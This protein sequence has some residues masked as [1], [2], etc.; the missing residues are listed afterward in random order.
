MAKKKRPPV[1]Q[2]TWSI[3][4]VLDPGTPVSSVGCAGGAIVVGS[5][6]LLRVAPGGWMLQQRPV[7]DGLELPVSLA[8]EP[9]PPFRVAIGPEDG[10]VVIFTDTSTASSIM[11][12]G[13]S[14]TRGSK[15]AKELC[16]VVNDGESSLY[17]RTDDDN[18]YRMQADAIWDQLE[19][20]PVRAVA[21]DDAG[22]FAA[23]TVVDGRPRVYITPDGGDRFQ[24]R[25][26]GVDVEAAPDAPAFMALAGTAVV[27]G[28]GDSGPM[29]SRDAGADTLRYPKL[30]RAFSAAFPGPDPQGSIYV[31]QQRRG[32]TPAQVWLL[33]EAGGEPL[34]VME[35]LADDHEALDLERVVWDP[36]RGALLI[37]SRGGMLALS[38]ETKGPKKKAA[39][40]PLLQ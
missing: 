25:D 32:P 37:P 1:S 19:I 31:A 21:C 13:F 29:V 38:P 22:G 17:A 4:E 7:P 10:D 3:R 18:V 15:Q 27:V 8:V 30:D 9:R 12:H 33:D 36:A 11:G 2:L 35:F 26:L 34:M 5:A 16:W 28:V 40:K 20:P 14:E 6:R 39:K 24:L 23:L